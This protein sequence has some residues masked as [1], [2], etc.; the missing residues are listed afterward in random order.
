MPITKRALL[1]SNP[2]ET[3][4]ENYCRGVYVDVRNYVTLLTSP[5]GG[6]WEAGEIQTLDRPTAKEVQL[7]IA[8]F[9]KY[10]Y[11]FVMFTGHGWFSSVDKDRILE[12]KKGEA[13]AS[14]DLLKGT[15]K[16]TLVL[17]C[18]QKVHAESLLQKR[19]MQFSG[20]IMANEA[21]LRTPNREACRKL[22]SD[23]IAISESGFVRMCSCQIGELS[24]DDDS[25]GGYYNSN[26]ID[27]ADEW[28]GRQAR[29]TWGGSASLSVVEAHEPAA[30]ATRAKSAG[31]QNPTIEKARTG[32]YFP[33]AVF[34]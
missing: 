23:T 6:A 30:A 13:I 16:R 31:K 33:F 8:D 34:A 19:A 7:W 4:A 2:G 22:F 1:I 9:S 21:R 5:Q 26:L 14:N 29:N 10:D 28:A 17:D 15:K 11:A 24:R 25:T 12:L 18:C 20:A 3:G 27:T 32:P